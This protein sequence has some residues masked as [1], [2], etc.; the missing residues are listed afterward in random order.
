MEAVPYVLRN[1]DLVA[2]VTVDRRTFLL[3]LLATAAVRGQSAGRPLA[4]NSEMLVEY[5]A[6][7]LRLRAEE[8]EAERS[9]I[10]TKS[11]IQKRNQGVRL[12]LQQMLGPAFAKCP[13][14]PRRTAVLERGEY[15]IE[16]VLFQ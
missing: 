10:H 11:Q 3:S 1:P 12:K 4:A 14:A 2:Q 15:R 16:N 9:A 7:R 8:M 6:R 5:F 13:L